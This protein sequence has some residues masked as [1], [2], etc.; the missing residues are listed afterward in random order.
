MEGRPGKGRTS[1][2][3]HGLI[4][5]I[6][7]S[8]FIQVGPTYDVLCC[9]VQ[10]SLESKASALD[11][12]AFL[13]SL[14]LLVV[15]LVLARHEGVGELCG[16]FQSEVR[17][18]S[19]DFASNPL[20]AF[21]TLDHRAVDI[22]DALN[23][24]DHGAHIFFEFSLFPSISADGNIGG[25]EEGQSGNDEDAYDDEGE[26]GEV[27]LFLV[28][29]LTISSGGSCVRRSGIVVAGSRSTIGRSRGA[30]RGSRGS[31]RGSRSAIR[32]S[33]SAV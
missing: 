12:L 16:G 5:H 15:R 30:I 23:N 28:G 27:L 33:W 3:I 32:G 18:Q 9:G 8:S 31:I 24:I 17:S 11:L 21:L 25:E 4:H 19:S 22:V 7:S 20:Q 2:S 26:V 6:G 1:G 13:A 14:E 10:I 29:H